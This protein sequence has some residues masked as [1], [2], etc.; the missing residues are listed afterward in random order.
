LF[1]KED[2]LNLAAIVSMAKCEG[3]NQAMTI[4]VLHDKLLKAANPAPTADEV[5]LTEE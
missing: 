2:F 5:K 3:V 4:V 1:T